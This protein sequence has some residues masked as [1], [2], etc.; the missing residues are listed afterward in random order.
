MSNFKKTKL[1]ILGLGCVG[2]PNAIAWS[3]TELA[4]V[5]AFDI[6]KKKISRL[7]KG[8]YPNYIPKENHAK[9]LKIKYTSN[10]KSLNK[11]NFI[12]A[13]VPTPINKS[14]KPDLHYLKSAAKIIGENIQKSSIVVLEST[15]YPGTTETIFVK[16]IE[17][18]SNLKCGP[19]FKIAYSPERINP[20]DN[21]HAIDKTIKIIS[22]QDKKTLT[23]VEK[24]YS[25]ICKKGMHKVSNIKT[26]EAT[27]LTENIQ[28]DVNIA[29][30]NELSKLFKKLNISTHEVMKAASTK[31]NI[32][33]YEPGLVGGACLPKDPYYLLYKAN[34]LNVPL[35]IT[36]ISRKINEQMPNYIIQ[37]TIKALKK[38]NKK[39]KN[40]KILIVGLAYKLNIQSIKAAPIKFVIE[41]LKNNG[42][43]IFGYEPLLSSIKIK[44]TFGIKILSDL[45]SLDKFDSIILNVVHDSEK[46]ILEKL[47]KISSS[48][49]L[50]DI[51]EFLLKK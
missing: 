33:Y 11:A 9:K 26:A 5:L 51:K 27:K 14:K 3:K 6:N 37:E 34:K 13:C 46:I 42:G 38:K 29:L 22:A 18:F 30:V 7:K 41:A 48:C 16:I 2:L 19:Q 10:P 36:K 35:E 39:I 31:W 24:T 4:P 50:I 44:K 20:G 25:L 49:T 47:K 40:S 32:Q 17:K 12:I 23:K 45:S 43:K 28:R 1:A 8:N 21:Q 15:V